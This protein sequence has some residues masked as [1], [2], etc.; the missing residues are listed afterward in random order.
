MN[1][2][3]LVCVF[4]VIVMLLNCDYRKLVDLPELQE[5]KDEEVGFRILLPCTP[6]KKSQI[7]QENPKLAR[8]Y[9]ND[10]SYKNLIVNLGLAEHLSEISS[11]K[12]DE[13]LESQVRTLQ[14]ML[15]EAGDNQTIV[16][17]QKFLYNEKYKAIKIGFDKKPGRRYSV[18]T[19]RG[20]YSLNLYFDKSDKL[21]DD[22][23]QIDYK[24][25]FDEIFDSFEIIEK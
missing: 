23:R 13:R 20:N 17:S 22:L 10:C 18:I 21:S 11:D 6:K 25:L 24:G 1:L 3:K 8:T 9:F 4:L 15:K 7:L 12:A 19:P 16:T 5:V 14:E 2:L